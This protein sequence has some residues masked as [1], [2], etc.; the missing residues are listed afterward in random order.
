MGDAIQAVKAGILE[1]ADVLRDQQGGPG[2]RDAD[3]PR[4]SGHDRAGRP[5]AGRL[6][7]A[8]RRTVAVRPEGIDEL[9]AAIGKHRAWLAEHG[10]LVRAAGAR[11]AV[12]IEEIALGTLRARL[13]SVREGTG[14]P[15]LAAAVAAGR[16]DP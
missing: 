14:L 9:V 15:E 4:H 2:R 12:E 11:A 1:I 10:E 13:G 6:A 7:A 5:E 8:G 3:V 16:T